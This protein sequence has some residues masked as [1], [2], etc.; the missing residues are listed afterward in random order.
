[1][2]SRQHFQITLNHGDQRRLQ[3]GPLSHDE[4]KPVPAGRLRAAWTVLFGQRVTPLQMQVEWIEY[5]LIFNDILTR[6]GAQLARE[7]QV[8]KRKAK[9]EEKEQTQAAPQRVPSA[10]A[11]VRTRVASMLLG[12]RLSGGAPAVPNGVAIEESDE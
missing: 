12:G 11:A 1:V 7:V 3:G 4:P 10:K 9:R 2:L 5:K 6:F 8:E